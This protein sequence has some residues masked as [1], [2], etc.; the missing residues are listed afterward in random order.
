MPKIFVT[1]QIPDT[2]IKMLKAKK[3]KIKINPYDRVLSQ[4]EIIKMGKGSDALLPMLTDKIDAKLL[5]GLGKQLKL[6]SQLAVGYDNIDLPACKDRNI[7]VTNT[8]GVLTESVAEHTFAMIMSVTKRILE[9]D[10]FTKA[11]K[12]KSWAPM[13]FLT[14]LLE[15]STLGII[16]LG[17]IGSLVTKKAVIGMDMKVVYTDIKRNKD[18]EKKYK[19]KYVSLSVLM[20]T[21]D[22]IS[23][24]VPLLP[25][26]KHLVS[27][28]L[29]SSMK[30]TA[31]LIN[32]SRGPVIDEAA[33]YQALI[34]NKIAGV[35]LDVFECEPK[36]ACT[37]EMRKSIK[38]LDNLIITPHM[39]SA[40]FNARHKMSEICAKNII[41]H[42]AGKKLFTP[43]KY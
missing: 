42:F 1:R 14:P 19:A 38:K 17:R 30:K 36:I 7:K 35:A 12:Y 21:A 29:I 10:K 27:K 37:A 11:E 40:T 25:S 13:L 5:D 9:A 20:K 32:T 15:E 6:V 4:A 8:P 2:G 28:K 18:F 24:H 33:L 34:K 31:Y 26:T 43:V 41:A 3:F 39:A 16:G 22:V 23:V